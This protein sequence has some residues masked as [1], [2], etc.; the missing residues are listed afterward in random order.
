MA[1]AA[2]SIA[3][4]GLQG[5]TLASAIYI[6]WVPFCDLCAG[7]AGGAQSEYLGVLHSNSVL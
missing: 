5:E 4:N 2:T 7:S 1:A 6:G 3:E